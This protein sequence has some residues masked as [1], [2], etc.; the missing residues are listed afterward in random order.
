[1]SEWEKELRSNARHLDTLATEL[2][3]SFIDCGGTKETANEWLED[4]RRVIQKVMDECKRR[5]PDGKED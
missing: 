3:E 2:R 4:T 5:Y 1:M